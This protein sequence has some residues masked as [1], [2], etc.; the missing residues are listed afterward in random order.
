M[1]DF[2]DIRQLSLTDFLSRQLR[3]EPRK[4][5]RSFRF[6]VCPDCGESSTKS[7]KLKVD[8]ADR[9]CKCHACGFSGDILDVAMVLWGMNRQECINRLLNRS[10]T[11]NPIPTIKPRKVIDQAVL[12]ADAK[13]KAESLKLA[14]TKLQELS[15]SYISDQKCLDYL[16]IE[17]NIPQSLI[18]EAQRRKML[19]FLPSD[20][21]ECR[22][23]VV[24]HL[25]MDLLHA[26]GL[27]KEGKKA[28]AIFFR[29]IM[30]F[31]PGAHA[32][33][34]RMLGEPNEDNPKSICYGSA[35]LPYVWTQQGS[36]RGVVLEGFIDMLS[37]VA[38]GYKGNVIALIGCGSFQR[39]WFP[40]LAKRLDIKHFVVA[41][42]NDDEADAYVRDEKNKLLNPGQT[43]AQNLITVLKELKLDHQHRKPPLHVD[44]NS[45]LQ[46]RQ[47]A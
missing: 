46:S 28:S 44:F 30:F 25:G 10:G 9:R 41:F 20:P 3:Q 36:D 38:L 42:D 35:K 11:D 6:S 40:Y 7:V 19:G 18:V 29:P 24:D 26:S 23:V 4:M 21:H 32:A 22:K 31:T 43:A 16:M 8:V 17:R 33:E 37:S 1:S 13:Q 15:T 34:F 14:L 12:D 39:D 47:A 5:A 27:W 45:I 2:D